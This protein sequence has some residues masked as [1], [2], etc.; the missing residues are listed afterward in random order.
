MLGQAGTVCWEVLCHENDLHLGRNICP[1]PVYNPCL[2]PSIAQWSWHKGHI[3]P[4]GVFW[5]AS[6]PKLNTGAG[7]GLVCDSKR[8][9]LGES[10]FVVDFTSEICQC[11]V[12]AKPILWSILHWMANK[13]LNGCDNQRQD[14]HLECYLWPNSVREWNFWVL[15]AALQWSRRKIQ[16]FCLYWPCGSIVTQSMDIRGCKPV[17]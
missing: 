13:I 14:Y 15:K 1:S 9:W 7:L 16:G 2:N 4:I 17:Q 6:F 5:V 3:M 12:N 11:E 10:Y 8:E